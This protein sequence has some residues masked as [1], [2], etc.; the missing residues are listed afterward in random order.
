MKMHEYMR[1][2]MAYAGHIAISK[3]SDEASHYVD[4]MQRLSDDLARDFGGERD[5]IRDLIRK[6]IGWAS[7]PVQA[8]CFKFGVVGRVAA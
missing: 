4:E 3:T 2:I 6:G 8:V 7:G 5:D 1:S